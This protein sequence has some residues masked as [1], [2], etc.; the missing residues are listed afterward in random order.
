MTSASPKG[1]ELLDHDTPGVAPEACK[2][3]C[4]GDAVPGVAPVTWGFTVAPSSFAEVTV[5]AVC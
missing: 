4:Q 1:T 3:A 5:L 2:A